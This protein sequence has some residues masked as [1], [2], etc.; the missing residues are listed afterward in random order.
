ML[1]GDDLPLNAENFTAAVRSL[2][3]L[4]NK[5]MTNLSIVVDHDNLRIVGKAKPPAEQLNVKIA[6][7]RG[8][9]QQVVNDYMPSLTGA[10][11][12]CS[13][14]GFPIAILWSETL[15]QCVLLRGWPDNSEMGRL[16]D[17]A[18]GHRFIEDKD[19]V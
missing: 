18:A 4:F 1:T 8:L 5:R 12:G 9:A 6:C 19:I 11:L 17:R 14:N 7:P 3:V 10:I 2:G 16:M 13:R 15:I